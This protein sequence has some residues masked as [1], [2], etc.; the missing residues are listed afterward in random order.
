RP[1]PRSRSPPRR[2]RGADRRDDTGPRARLPMLTSFTLP[3]INGVNIDM[4]RR[5]PPMQALSHAVSRPR[6]GRPG[7]IAWSLMAGLAV[8]LGLASLR[9]LTADP[10]VAPEALRANMAAQTA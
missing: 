9:Y 8:A 10:A 3:D 4:A 6:A 1:P 7:T 2:E 5:S